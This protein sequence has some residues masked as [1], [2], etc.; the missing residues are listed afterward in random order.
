MQN[1]KYY[2]I[3]SRLV[4]YKKVDLVIQAFNKLNLPLVIV[5]AGREEKKLKDIAKNNIKF[6]GQ[7]SEEK[8]ANYYENAKALVMPQE[9]DFGI[10][11]IEAQ[12]FGVPVIAFKKGGALDT[13]IE[14]KTGVFFDR[15]TLESLTSAIEKFSKISFNDKI[16]RANAKRFS[17]EVFKR[18]LQKSLVRAN[19]L[20]RRGN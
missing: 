11:V 6:A 20:W 19:F 14:N 9:E 7:V 15:Q 17:K 10:V 16:I 1:L 12:N 5:G 4:K 18:Q 13:V 2:L 3:V 8:L